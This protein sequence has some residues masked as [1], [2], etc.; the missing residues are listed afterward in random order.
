VGDARIDAV[1]TPTDTP[2]IRPSDSADLTVIDL[3]L[4]TVDFTGT[5]FGGV[6]LD[7][8][9]MMDHYQDRNGDNLQDTGDDDGDGVINEPNEDNAISVVAE[10]VA[11]DLDV[12]GPAW[13]EDGPDDDLDPE[14][15]KHALVPRGTRFHVLATFNIEDASLLGPDPTLE[16]WATSNDPNFALGS[17]ENPVALHEVAG[18]WEGVFQV[19]N[20][21]EAIGVL[22]DLTWTW[23]VRSD[24][25]PASSKTS[26]THTI[27]VNKQAFEGDFAGYVPYDWVA[28]L[29]V[30]WAAGWDQDADI[31]QNIGLSTTTSASVIPGVEFEYEF[32]YPTPP[33]TGAITRDLLQY[34]QNSYVG[35]H[36]RYGACGT[37]AAF[38]TDL[39]RVQSIAVNTHWVVSPLLGAAPGID[40]E[41]AWYES[42]L[43]DNIFYGSTNTDRDGDHGPGFRNAFG[44][45]LFRGKFVWPDHVFNEYQGQIY[46]ASLNRT[47]TM[48]WAEYFGHVM[49]DFA[50]IEDYATTPHNVHFSSKWTWTDDPADG[51]VP[52]AHAVSQDP[53]NLANGFEE[54]PDGSIRFY[55]LPPLE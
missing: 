38:L 33:D 9:P 22:E 15:N 54:N 11:D 47:E 35:R 24:Q 13:L 1:F 41:P 52:V 17:E 28:W 36:L 48:S 2:D 43:D 39:C 14:R 7:G 3:R 45:Y 55:E 19:E 10:W 31:V 46:D 16:A 18:K 42:Y 25:L 51:S 27:L 40:W 12:G 34:R 30:A 21:P 29:S 50:T 8:I 44:D 4:E 32:P 23:H 37:Y 5:T 6:D 20:A 49:T 53:S 26:S